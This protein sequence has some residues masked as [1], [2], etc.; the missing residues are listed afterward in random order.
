MVPTAVAVYVD[1]VH[2]TWCFE[3][4]FDFFIKIKKEKLWIK[5]VSSSGW[6]IIEKY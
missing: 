4:I 2:V 1:N 6:H 3:K 5:N